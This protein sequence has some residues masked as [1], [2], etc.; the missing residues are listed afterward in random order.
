MLC[1]IDWLCYPGFLSHWN[2]AFNIRFPI[3]R[4]EYFQ[5]IRGNPQIL[6]ASGSL[7]W[8]LQTQWENWR[9]RGG[10]RTDLWHITASYKAPV[11]LIGWKDNQHWF[12]F[13][14][15]H[16]MVIHY[17]TLMET[18]I[19]GW[20]LLLDWLITVFVKFEFV[21]LLEYLPRISTNGPKIRKWPYFYWHATYR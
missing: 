16:V 11:M 2:G 20:L 1:N 15:Y 5:R 6:L 9:G 3:F 14:S 13:L 10:Q 7:F 17:S 8:N 18:F 12:K 4:D 21:F 19:V